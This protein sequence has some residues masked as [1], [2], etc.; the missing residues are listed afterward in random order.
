M[1]LA[2]CAEWELEWVHRR[3]SSDVNPGGKGLGLVVYEQLSVHNLTLTR[4]GAGGGSGRAPYTAQL[5]D[6]F[7][8]TEWSDPR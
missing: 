7:G 3:L 4:R 1:N 8:F 5:V 6:A 2:R